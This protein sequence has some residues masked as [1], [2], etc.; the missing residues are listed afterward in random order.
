MSMN[1]DSFKGAMKGGGARPNLFRVRGGFPNGASSAVATLGGATAGALGGAI[2]NAA[3][4]VINAVAGGGP[5]RKA[6]FLIKA[7]SLPASTINEIP[8]PFRGR[9]LFIPGDRTFEP[10][11]ITVINDT[12]FDIRNAFEAWSNGIN[13]HTGNVGPEGLAGITQ[14]WEVDQLNRQGAVIKSYTFEGCWPQSIDAID[15]SFES[16][17][18]IEEF[19]VQMRYQY[20]RSNTTD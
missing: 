19:T 3:G 8:V 1:I 20:W 4:A 17:D 12:D 2:G 13:A 10:W 15:L 9:Q 11:T 16:V 18:T 5:G 7:A 14:T 6:E